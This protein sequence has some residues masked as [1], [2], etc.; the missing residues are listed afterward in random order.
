MGYPTIPIFVYVCADYITIH[1]MQL[2]DETASSSSSHDSINDDDVNF[3]EYREGDEGEGGEGEDMGE[4][5]SNISSYKGTYRMDLSSSH[6]I[7][8]SN[9]DP[10]KWREETERVA[11]K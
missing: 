2:N 10:S 7:V 1:L 6:G 8:Y 11:P 4:S 5:A 3:S 9:V